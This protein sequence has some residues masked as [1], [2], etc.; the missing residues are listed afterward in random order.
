VDSHKT[1]GKT[2]LR[3]LVP[4]G[5]DPP[6]AVDDNKIYIRDEA[7]TNLAVRDEI[8]NLVHRSRTFTAATENG[9]AISLVSP[10][11]TTTVIEN[12]SEKLQPPRTGV[13]VVNETERS[14]QKFYTLRD[15]RNGNVVKNVTLKSARRLWHYALTTYS[16]L[17]K[18]IKQAKIDWKGEIG[19]MKRYKHGNRQIFDLIQ[20]DGKNYHYYYG[21]TEDGV[22]GD[23]RRLVGL[24]E[25]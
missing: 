24:S 14:N 23:W 11:V 25:D 9:D 3:I 16:N 1:S 20:R 13:E 22:H 2:V 12:A 17:P 19:L 10:P 8:V 7:E 6:Y 21:V 18:D 4:R 15:L 5:E